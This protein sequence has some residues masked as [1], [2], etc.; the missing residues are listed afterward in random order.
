MPPTKQTKIFKTA[1]DPTESHGTAAVPGTQQG[2]GDRFC[3]NR[4]ARVVTSKAPLEERISPVGPGGLF[5]LPGCPGPPEAKAPRYQ[6]KLQ[7]LQGLQAY[8][9]K[10]KGR[11]KPNAQRNQRRVHLIIS[12][13]ARFGHLPPA[14]RSQSPPSLQNKLVPEGKNSP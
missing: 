6:H 13:A 8:I 2:L 4:S 3:T 5:R 11:S 10:V 7:G 14:N 12:G 9:G 1:S